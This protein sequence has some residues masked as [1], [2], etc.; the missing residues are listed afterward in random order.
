MKEMG[1][2]EGMR[3]LDRQAEAQGAGWLEEK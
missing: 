3:A 2:C 1:G